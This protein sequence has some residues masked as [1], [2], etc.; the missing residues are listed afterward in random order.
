MADISVALELDDKQYLNALKRAGAEGDKFAKNTEQNVEKTSKAFDG[1]SKVIA[2]IGFG[3]LI[4][5]SINLGARLSNLSDATGLT[6]ARIKGLQDAFVTSGGTADQAADGI[7]DLIKNI[8]EAA[9]GSNE[10]ISAFQKVGVSLTDLQ[11]LSEQDILRKVIKGLAGIPDVATRTAIGMKIMGESIK[12][13][14]LTNVNASF[15]KFTVKAANLDKSAKSAAEAQK[16]L[17]NAFNDVQVGVLA[18]IEP[19]SK[20]VAQLAKNT[21]GIATFVEYAVKIGSVVAT[22]FAVGK[23]VQ[24]AAGTFKFLSATVATAGGPLNLVTNAFRNFGLIV[25]QLNQLGGPVVGLFKLLKANI[26]D[27]AYWFGRAI[28]IVGTLG[29]AFWAFGDDIKKAYNALKEFFGLDFSDDSYAKKEEARAAAILEQAENRKR[30]LQVLIDEKAALESQLTAYNAVNAATIKKIQTETELIG[31]SEEYRKKVQELTQ[32]ESTYLTEV[33][34][35]RDQYNKA[36]SPEQKEQIAAAEARL[37]EEYNRQ[38][39]SI[40]AAVAAQESKVRVNNLEKFSIDALIQSNAEIQRIQDEIAKVTM[41]ALEKAYYD[42]EAAAKASAEAAIAAEEIR[43]GLAPGSMAEAERVKYY[44][45]AAVRVRELQAAT[46]ELAKAETAR[47][48]GLAIAR[49]RLQI[50]NDIRRVQDEMATMTM[51][52][53]EKKEYAIKRAAE[54]RARAYIAA[55]E[56]RTG[57]KMSSDDQKRTIK[58]YVDGTNDLIQATRKSHE[59]SQS[60][61]TGWK[62]AMNEYVQNV[63]NGAQRAKNLFATATKGMEDLIINFAKTGK[64]EWQGFL[65]SIVEQL[66]RSE[67]QSLI[68]KTFSGLSGASSTKSSSPAKSSGSSILGNLFSGFAGFFAEGGKIPAGQW[69]IAGEAGAEIIQGPA[70]VTP[71]GD[72]PS[73]SNNTYNINYSISAVDARSFQQLVAQDPEFIY[74]VTLKGQ[75]MM[76]KGIR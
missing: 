22:F 2:G 61:T 48:Q 19:L 21:E 15:D 39:E 65:N 74:A 28:P 38:R 46:Y 42:V 52:E 72:L 50:E 9:T 24:L 58:E 10:L 47:E 26:L 31:K 53:I 11:N 13:V 66:L 4:T 40:E 3:A 1:L 14:D 12:G 67:I 68:A 5:Q 41:P 62:Q 59:E 23:A 18:G 16:A 69:G 37:T 33:S 57:N 75:T 45:A 27:I 20:S 71:V 36:A 30:L 70:A 7:S 73:S 43:R 6:I 32:A 34:K 49:E 8:G 76:P 17:S 29:A 51:T 44:E 60:W 54:D 64:F 35:L 55:E 25:G 56:A 63:S